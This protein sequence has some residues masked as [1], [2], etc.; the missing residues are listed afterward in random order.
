MKKNSYIVLGI[1]VA[2]ISIFLVATYFQKSKEKEQIERFAELQKEY[3]VRSYSPT[4]G[5]ANAPVTIVEF[6]DPECEACRAAYPLMKEVLQ[7][8]NG[9]AQLVLRY[10]TFHKNSAHA[11]SMLEAARKQ[12]KYW[13][14]LEVMFARQPEWASHESPKPELLISYMKG[15]GLDI[16]R[17]QDSMKDT[18]I[19]SKIMQDRDDGARLEVRSTPTVF[20]N[21]RLISDLTYSALMD[22]INKYSK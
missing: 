16:E 9:K 5:S 6:F 8:A 11:V 10:M 7:N 21:G 2:A 1:L 22:A 4:L 13:E 20:V 19:Q 17:L 15:I 14:A 3:L 18:E 12:G